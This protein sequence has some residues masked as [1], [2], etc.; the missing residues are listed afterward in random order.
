MCYLQFQ[1]VKQKYFYT[2][3]FQFTISYC[4]QFQNK[5]AKTIHIILYFLPILDSYA[6][7]KSLIL[8]RKHCHH[9]KGWFINFK[10]IFTEY[11]LVLKGQYMTSVGQHKCKKWK[12]T[13]GCMELHLPQPL[14][15]FTHLRMRSSSD[16]RFTVHIRQ[17]QSFSKNW[18]LPIVRPNGAMKQKTVFC[19]SKPWVGLNLF[20]DVP[21]RWQGNSP[22]SVMICDQ[23][24]GLGSTQDLSHRSAYLA[25][26]NP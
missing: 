15:V 7:F 6:F 5:S 26:G 8:R 23:G 18:L 2:L 17:V 11:I 10:L 24:R 19:K 22:L 20:T 13:E 3:I 12:I 14:L 4:T 16:L 25:L 9:L 1:N 21:I